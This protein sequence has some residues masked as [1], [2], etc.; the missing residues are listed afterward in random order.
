[1]GMGLW[2]YPGSHPGEHQ[3]G[4]AMTFDEAGADFERAWKI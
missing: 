2:F 4:T 3:N 1:M